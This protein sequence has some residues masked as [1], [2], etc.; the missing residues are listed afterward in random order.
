MKIFFFSLLLGSIA[1]HAADS[2]KSPTPSPSNDVTVHERATWKNSLPAG[3]FIRLKDKTLLTV[4]GAQTL[5]SRDEGQTWSTHSLFSQPDTY[6]T[7]AERALVRTRRNTLVL[8]FINDRERVW[9]WDKERG[10]PG[11]GVTLPTYVTR[12]LDEGKTWETPQMLHRDWSGAIRNMIE[13]ADGTLVFTT[14]KILRNPGRH[15]C[16]T[17]RS[18]D[19]G[20]TWT[21]SNLLDLGGHGHHDGAL[22]PAIVQLKDGRIWMLIRT[23]LGTF[24]ESHSSDL[25]LTWSTPTPTP[26]EASTAPP[27]LE[28][29][30]SGRLMLAWNRPNLEGK[31]SHPLRGGDNQWS[32]KPASNQ[33][34]ELSIAFSSDDGKTWSPPAVLVRAQKKDTSYPYLF[35]LNPGEIWVTTMRETVKVQLRERDFAAAR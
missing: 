29:L 5:T 20:A 24:Y 30:E 16:L 10:E 21:A 8:A 26:I 33:R 19:D 1:A 7:R 28:R 9:A 23:T 14:M 12:S 6:T 25:G 18:T 22:E 32:A 15:G 35:E 11:D 3:P 2:V 4:D 17:Y 31:D 27:M 13:C 34:S